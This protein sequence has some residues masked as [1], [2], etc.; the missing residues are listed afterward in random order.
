MSLWKQMSLKSHVSDLLLLGDC[1]GSCL[2]WAFGQS[3]QGA[4]PPGD[5]R[6]GGRDAEDWIGTKKVERGCLLVGAVY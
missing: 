3:H 6:A 1:P 2:R 4:L 5:P